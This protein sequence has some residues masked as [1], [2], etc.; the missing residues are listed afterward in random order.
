M[1]MN[2][3]LD[4]NLREKNTKFFISVAIQEESILQLQGLSKYKEGLLRLCSLYGL[5]MLPNF[6]LY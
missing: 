6:K 3:V 4:M 5:H 1:H 2:Q